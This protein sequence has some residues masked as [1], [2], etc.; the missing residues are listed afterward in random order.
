LLS[1]HPSKTVGE[2]KSKEKNVCEKKKPD[3]PIFLGEGQRVTV[4]VTEG[5]GHTSRKD[6][7]H[8]HREAHAL[9]I[10]QKTKQPRL[11][12]G[13]RLRLIE[14]K[15]GGVWVLRNSLELCTTVGAA[16]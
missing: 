11:G 9:K 10:A 8:P 5:G 14:K 1:A 16:T 3:L 4:A 2:E 7:K 15:R 13:V 6:L 12:G